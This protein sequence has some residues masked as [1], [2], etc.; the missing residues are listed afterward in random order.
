[1][2][3]GAGTSPSRTRAA[4]SMIEVLLAVA[5]LGIV[6]S[7]IVGF[8]SAVAARGGQSLR[9]SEPAIDASLA[10]QRLSVIAPAIRCSLATSET[11]AI[12]WLSDDIPNFGVE[13]SEVGVL[14]FVTADSELV[15][16]TIDRAALS[17]D[18]G[19]DRTFPEDSLGDIAGYFDTLRAAGRLRQRILAENLEDVAFETP[20]DAVGTA[21][22]RFRAS[23]RETLAILSPIPLELPLR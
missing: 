20:A 13:A 21:V 7:A 3:V 8:M 2:K 1:M 23:D 18:M 22:A 11:T 19:L 14:R 12:L 17:S 4:F 15:L 9:Q 6:S 5:L 10:M 16:E